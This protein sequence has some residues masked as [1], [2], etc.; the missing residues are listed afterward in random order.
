M[1]PLNVVLF[2]PYLLVTWSIWWFVWLRSREP[3][4]HRLG[5]LILARRLLA[6]EVPDDAAILVDLTAEFVEPRTVTRDRAYFA[7][8]ILDGGIPRIEPLRVFLAALPD[9]GVMLIHCAQ[10]HGRTAMVVACLLLE[11]RRATGARAAID[12]VLAARP[13]ARMTRAQRAFVE[14]Y[15]ETLPGGS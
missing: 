1:R 8:P 5:T 9:A 14:A 13:G 7:F 11:R 10:G 3:P 4:L 2:A 15:G 12:L 6:H